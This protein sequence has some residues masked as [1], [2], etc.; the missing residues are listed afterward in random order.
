[1]KYC[2]RNT[3][4]WFFVKFRLF[5][6]FFFQHGRII[7]QT[8]VL[9]K[10]FQVSWH[11]QGYRAAILAFK[12]R[13]KKF[14][15][16]ITLTDDT[17][18]QNW[19]KRKLWFTYRKKKEEAKLTLS[20]EH[21]HAPQTFNF[22]SQLRFRRKI[23]RVSLGGAHS[24][25]CRREE[26]NSRSSRRCRYKF[27]DVIVGNFSFLFRGSLRRAARAQKGAKNLRYTLAIL[28]NRYGCSSFS[29]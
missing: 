24:S 10:K 27:A 28:I 11:F 20:S 18:Y 3:G 17:S 23:N 29:G 8:L 5:F 1:M 21:P 7:Q 2:K 9:L 15:L 6:F 13:K 25:A 22:S 26:K 14:S 19:L 4:V 16:I 12:L